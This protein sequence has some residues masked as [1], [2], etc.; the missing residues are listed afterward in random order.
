MLTNMQNMMRFEDSNGPFCVFFDVKDGD[1]QNVTFR[2]MNG[3]VVAGDGN[4][5]G[6]KNVIARE[7]A[8]N[9]IEMAIIYSTGQ[10]PN[11]C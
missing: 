7:Y 11:L 1:I 2:D 5:D 8:A 3:D 10:A 9:T 6:L 4:L